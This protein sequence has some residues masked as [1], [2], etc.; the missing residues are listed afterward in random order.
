MLCTMA[1]DHLKSV[2]WFRETWIPF[3]DAKI[4][5]FNKAFMYGLYVFG[6]IRAQ[7]S[8]DQQALYAFRL[9]E[10]YKR[11]LNSCRVL[12]FQNFQKNYTQERF[13]ETILETL[14]KNNLQEDVYIR[15]F[16]FV[17]EEKMS[18]SFANDSFGV[19]LF[20]L[21]TYIPSTGL[22]CKVSSWTRTEDNAIS[23]HFKVGGAYVNTALAKHEAQSLGFDEAIVLDKN[24]YAVEG[25]AENLFIVRD[26]TLITPP[27][28]SNI[29]EGITRKSVIQLA[30][31]QN[32]PVV[33]RPIPRTELYRA[34]EVFLTGTA[35]RIASVAEIDGISI[36]NGLYPLTEKLQQ[37]LN[38]I[39]AGTDETYRHWLW[40]A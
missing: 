24:G 38:A 31:N 34:D 9:D 6:G 18:P 21:G 2:A 13:I 33:E 22:R 27:V 39:V 28:S 37:H 11:F 32:I 15:P 20:P 19:A 14:R 16:S 25:S 36:G 26:N 4:G 5:I 30:Q 7:W 1:F 23:S 12:R 40:K 17:D 3:A 10:H 8:T 29:L 35:A